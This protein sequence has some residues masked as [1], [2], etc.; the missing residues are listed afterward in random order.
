MLCLSRKVGEK[1]IIAGG[2]EIV[3]LSIRGERVQIGV[4]APA[5]ARI[6][7]KAVVDKGDEK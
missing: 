4:V 6:V 5:S 2:I 3:V 1:I 7:R